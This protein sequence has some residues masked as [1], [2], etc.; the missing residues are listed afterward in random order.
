M[1]WRLWHRQLLNDRLAYDEVSSSA[2]NEPLVIE[3][4]ELASED[5]ESN[6]DWE[7]DSAPPSRDPVVLPT[8]PR[9]GP[10]TRRQ[11]STATLQPAFGASSRSRRLSCDPPPVLSVSQPTSS[12]RPILTSESRSNSAPDGPYA[13]HASSHGRSIG[14]II[15]HLLPD[16]FDAVLPSWAVA[17]PSISATSQVDHVPSTPGTQPV[18]FLIHSP[19][20]PPNASDGNLMAHPPPTLMVIHPTPRPTPPD[21]PATRT[22]AVPTNIPAALSPSTTPPAL[23]APST[24][25]HPHSV[26]LPCPSASDRLVSAAA[27][28]L[29]P[30]MVG[31]P[32]MADDDSK[33]KIF[34]VQS[35][36]GATASDD[37]R[38]HSSS[39]NS[40]TTS[41][42]TDP[43]AAL[44][45]QQTCSLSSATTDEPAIAQ[46]VPEDASAVLPDV[47]ASRGANHA[48][49]SSGNAAY[50][51]SRTARGSKVSKPAVRLPHRGRPN[52]LVRTTSN[53]SD[54]SHGGA[55]GKVK[56][57]VRRRS[58]SEELVEDVEE[59]ETANR[60][61]SASTS[62]TVT[63]L[64][65]VPAPLSMTPAANVT[66]FMSISLHCSHIFGS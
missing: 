13:H 29:T 59:P 20:T 46:P 2:E 44:N 28:P 17:L 32:E 21:T 51:R 4:V 41:N 36:E 35:P 23:T 5:S 48:R 39:S 57:P 31:P 56:P 53:S 26:L 42:V 30:T 58:V 22:R 14:R 15:S 64:P 16:K 54:R 12:V 62:H 33:I 19:S 66:I 40:N 61:T 52:P 55:G 24:L 1:T 60:Q 50:I 45:G 38:S 8:M 18:Q 49:T 43:H 27:L 63:S 9:V 34:Y 7:D 3:A 6:D 37:G 65:T 47:S 11:S 25:S 10:S